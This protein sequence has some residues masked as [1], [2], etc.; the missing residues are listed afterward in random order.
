[1]MRLL[2]SLDCSLRRDDGGLYLLYTFF[3]FSRLTSTVECVL[4]PVAILASTDSFITA[5]QATPSLSSMLC[6]MTVIP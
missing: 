6:I 2:P 1:M 5:L 4:L 3:F